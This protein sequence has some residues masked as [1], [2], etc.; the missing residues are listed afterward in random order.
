MKKRLVSVALLAVLST[1]AVSCQKE[2]L[3]E[4]QSKNLEVSTVY[5]VRYVVNGITHT[6]TLGS[7]AEY[8]ALLMRLLALARLGYEVEI[9][10]GVDPVGA[11]LAVEVITFS[12]SNEQEAA[13]WV[14][15]KVLE[16]YKVHVSFDETTGMFNCIA[17]R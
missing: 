3:A 5:T 7:D 1:V 9:M 10:N 4:P 2:T 6:E 14:K 13:D 11:T 8:D 15:Q 16:G 17:Y 12:T